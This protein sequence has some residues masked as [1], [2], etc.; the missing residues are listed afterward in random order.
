LPLCLCSRRRAVSWLFHSINSIDSLPNADDEEQDTLAWQTTLGERI[1]EII[2][3]KRSSI[4][5]REES[6]SSLVRILTQH[7]A[8]KEVHT[9]VTDLL[10]AFGKSIKAESSEKETI[11]ALK[12]VALIIITQPEDNYYELLSPALKRTVTDSE[13]L[14]TKAA[15]IHCLGECTF[16]G[17]AGDD[18]IMEVMTFLLEI[19][20]S[21]GSSVDAQDDSGTVTAALEEWGFLATEIDDLSAESED[22]IETLMEQLDSS[23]SSVQIAAGENIALLY[24]KSYGEK[25]ETDSDEEDEPSFSDDEEDDSGFIISD[26][27]D[28]RELPGRKLTKKYNAY[29]NTP[30]LL[31]K[32]SSLATLS[33]H[34][35][36]KKSK[37]N[38]HSSF[39]SILTSVEN[40]RLGPRYQKALDQDTGR[41]L[42]SRM[43]VRIHKSGEMKVDTWWKWMRL[44]ALRR[45]LQG[46][47]VNHY[48]EGNRA[49]LE[50]LPIML[51]QKDELPEGSKSPRPKPKGTQRKLKTKGWDD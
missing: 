7:Y 43:T 47:F 48:F 36:S 33:T 26:D 13:S 12:A 34:K 4:Q 45:V 6:L 3:R 1:E 28:E 22:M 19:V 9:R 27:S 31:T 15:A 41:Q 11:L 37:K 46:G 24:E 8:S 5:G 21:D 25:S 16:F 35:I 38:L 18:E 20:S 44:G 40:P 50:S 2:D 51:I 42:G 49:V 32:L 39:T 17:G 14:P 10:Q 23:D 30:L 29:H